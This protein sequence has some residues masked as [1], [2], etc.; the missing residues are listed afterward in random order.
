MARET[1]EP[2]HPR[3]PP[4]SYK[5]QYPTNKVTTT[6][7]GHEW[8]VDDTEGEERLRQVHRSG[9]Y[10]EVSKDGRKVELVVGDGYSYT[11]GGMT[12]TVDKN[13][14]IKVGGHY[15]LLVQ[16]DGHIEVKGKCGIA[17]EGDC[18]V[19][20]GQNL[21]AK[22][23]GDLRAGVTGDAKILVGGKTSLKSD[24]DINII[25]D[26]DIKM[27]AAG[28]FLFQ[29]KGYK[30]KVKGDAVIDIDGASKM[31]TAGNAK[32]IGSP[33]DLNP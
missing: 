4:T 22:V 15:R 27:L 31:K 9:T 20:V 6:R 32:I 14:D 28:D 17:V 19:T 13:N 25:S 24:G 10:W 33:I 3:L 26:G 18:S 2:I 11:K 5:A 21:S 12:L 1:D 23:G 29:C 8:H 30:H 7:S 16:G